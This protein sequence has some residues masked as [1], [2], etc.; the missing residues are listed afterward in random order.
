MRRWL[1]CLILVST[2]LCAQSLQSSP[3]QAGP[4]SSEE[5]R[6]ILQQL[7]ELRAA[8]AQ[9]A[10]YEE[11]IARDREQDKKEQELATRALEL[12]RKATTNAEARATLNQEKAD[13]YKSLLEASNKR[14]CGIGG[15]ILWIL[16]VGQRRCGG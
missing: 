15:R 2:R 1:W 5:K 3:P 12:E 10:T 7:V 14:G 9:I 8:R 6:L 16:T 4:L 13:M 11:F